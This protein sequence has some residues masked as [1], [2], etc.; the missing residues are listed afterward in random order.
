MRKKRDDEERDMKE[1]KMKKIIKK[2]DELGIDKMV[3]IG[4]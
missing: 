1:V 4:L 2:L 3:E